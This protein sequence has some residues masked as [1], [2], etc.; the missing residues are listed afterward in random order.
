MRTLPDETLIAI[1]RM[2]VAVGELES[3][4]AW[5]GGAPDET[6]PD[7]LLELARAGV[8]G[9][10]GAKRAALVGA[11]ATQLARAR[12]AARVLEGDAAAFDDITAFLLR[13]RDGLTHD[14]E[15]V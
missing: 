15:R 10:G 14:Q 12:V 9:G 2:T 3:L 6:R 11:A 1:G 4:L 13:V 8:R 7:R 5:L